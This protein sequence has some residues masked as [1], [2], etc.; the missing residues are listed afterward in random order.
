MQRVAATR[1]HGILEN[2]LSRLR[3]KKAHKY[4]TAKHKTGSILDIGCGAHPFHLINSQFT[5]KHGIDQ[6]KW[7]NEAE[8]VREYSIKLHTYDVEEEN[9]LPF[10]DDSFD[11]VTMLAVY[12]HIRPEVLDVLLAEIYRVL[13]TDGGRLII[14]TPSKYAEPVLEIFARFGIV[15]K[16]EIDEHQPL[17]RVHQ[18]KNTL[19]RAGFRD[20]RVRV[21]MFELMMNIYAVADK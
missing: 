1:G 20:D 16:V 10:T 3:T 9:H 19:A 6:I 13:K 15:S 12:E 7:E 8:L 11:I 2:Y 18:V 21:G 5:E 17:Q 14:T 4:I